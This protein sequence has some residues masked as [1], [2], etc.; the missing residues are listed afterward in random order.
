MD[1]GRS[2]VHSLDVTF[3]PKG[4]MPTKSN[5]DRAA[6]TLELATQLAEAVK[7][8]QK[9]PDDP[10]AWLPVA[11]LAGNVQRRSRLLAGLGRGG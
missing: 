3:L 11:T 7:L 8:A 5:E 9:T 10:A 4:I 1:N 2:I 6:E